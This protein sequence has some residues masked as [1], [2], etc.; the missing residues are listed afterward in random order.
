MSRKEGVSHEALSR[1]A[2]LKASAPFVGGYGIQLPRH[3]S[4]RPRKQQ[5]KQRIETD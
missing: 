4:S 1:I 3:S 5:H 2:A